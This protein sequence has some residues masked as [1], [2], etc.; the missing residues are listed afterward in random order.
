MN[1]RNGRD[2]AFVFGKKRLLCRSVKEAS[3]LFAK[4]LCVSPVVLTCGLIKRS[5]QVPAQ[6]VSISAY[7]RTMAKQLGYGYMQKL[8]FRALIWMEA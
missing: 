5:L 2:C 3:F 7:L 8:P 4:S 1:Y 6:G